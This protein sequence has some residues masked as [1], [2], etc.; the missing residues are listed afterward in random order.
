[1]RKMLCEIDLEKAQRYPG[2]YLEHFPTMNR[3]PAHA[4][5]RESIVEVGVGPCDF[6]HQMPWVGCETRA[7]FDEYYPE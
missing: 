7:D 6:L 4:E 1:M 3:A 2:R 5:F